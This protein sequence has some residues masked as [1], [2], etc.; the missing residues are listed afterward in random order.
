MFC[1]FTAVLLMGGTGCR[2]RERDD[3]GCHAPLLPNRSLPMTLERVFGELTFTKPVQLLHFPAESATWL[4]VLHTG[5]VERVRDGSKETYFDVSDRVDVGQQWG[6][7]EIALHPRFPEDPRIFIAYV[8]PNHVSVV[9]SLRAGQDGR[10]VDTTS[11]IVLLSEAQPGPWHPIAGLKF[12]PEGYLYVAWGEGSD[13]KS[14][15]PTLLGGKMLRI[16]VDRIADG[17]PYAIPPDNPYLGTPF[18]PETFAIGLRNP[19]RFSFD[20]ETGDIWLGDVGDRTYEEIDRIVGGGN[21]GWPAW[22][23]TACR[24]PAA[25][26][27][28]SVNRPVVQHSH[29]EMCS[30]TGGYV[31]RGRALPSLRGRY[32]YADFCSGTIWALRV[33]ESGMTVSEPIASN[34]RAIGSFAEDPDGELYVIETRDTPEDHEHVESGFMAHRLVANEAALEAHSTELQAQ[35]L[36]QVQC[37]SDLG[38]SAEP[39]GMVAYSINLGAWAD[40]AETLRFISRRASGEI[41]GEQD[42]IDRPSKSIV[43]KTFVRAGRPVETQLLVKLENRTW[44]ALDYEWTDDAHDALPLARGK[45]KLLQDGTTW[46]FPGPEGCSRCHHTQI[47][48]LRALTLSQLAGTVDGRD[49]LDWLTEQGVIKWRN[50]DHVPPPPVPKLDDESIPI[51]Q[52]AR[53]YLDVNCS[54]CHQPGGFAG[55]ATMDLRRTI[56]LTAA[57]I[58]AK[59]PNAIFPG[60]ENAVLLAPG[61]PEQSLISVRMHLENEGAMPPQRRRADPLGTQIIDAWI[62]SLTT[63]H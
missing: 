8:A 25:C 12:G 22:E 44:A 54:A 51:E 17:R 45:T 62:S 50:E 23:G 16:D 60:H 14:Q 39:E 56:P 18:R 4:V 30:V 31:Y 37:V 48:S 40:G 6:L 34:A 58:C 24:K 13:E 32:V 47:G 52:R 2:S 63:C 27:D 53:A 19:W 9:S 15:V 29:N 26:G 5:V 59:P 61:A 3:Q 7:Q 20:R 11:E 28:E 41:Y 55:E 36:S 46:T 1:V 42:M 49:Q 57:G 33:D 43:M 21:Y 38:F 35:P 10:T